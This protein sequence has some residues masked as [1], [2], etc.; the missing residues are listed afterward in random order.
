M[1]R[2]NILEILEDF[3]KFIDKG[4][5]MGIY[6]DEEL[7]EIEEIEQDLYEVYQEIELK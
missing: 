4:S 7:H 6:T 2:N 1:K 5:A 3:S